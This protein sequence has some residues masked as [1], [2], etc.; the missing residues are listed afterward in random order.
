MTLITTTFIIPTI[1]T[2]PAT[3]L[4]KEILMLSVLGIFL[5]IESIIDLKHLET[6]NYMNFGLIFVAFAFSIIN[7]IYSI[8]LA[9]LIS[10]ILGFALM[11]LLTFPMFYLGLWGGG[12]V[13]VLLGIGTLLGLSI[14]EIQSFWSNLWSIF[15][16][17]K[18]LIIS[19][20]ILIKF[21]L[22]S[23]ISS[24]VYGLIW[25]V[26]KII[27]NHKEISKIF[28]KQSNKNKKLRLINKVSFLILVLSI[29]SI[30]ISLFVFPNYSFFLL[31]TFFLFLT[32]FIFLFQVFYILEKNMMVA[33]IKPLD[34]TE[35]DWLN[36]DL[37][38]KNKII[39]KANKTGLTK[40]QI[41]KL[42]SLQ[43]KNKLKFVDIKQGIAYFPV[44]F[45]AILGLIFVLIFI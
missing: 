29:F 38:I 40:Q 5:L 27:K 22:L 30:S 7:S 19:T 32:L 44:F 34:L 14:N 17:S 6:P 16:T 24:L 33:K 31:S 11:A 28:K 12:D 43:K 2:I 45:L 1:I 20:P 10:A 9:P 37:K 18:E 13:K 39:C 25:A 4:D 35:G 21:L 42:I 26:I 41:K 15:T 3:L 36:K 23:L 8:S